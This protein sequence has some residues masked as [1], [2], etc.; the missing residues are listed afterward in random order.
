MYDKSFFLQKHTLGA[1]TLPHSQGAGR[2]PPAGGSAGDSARRSGNTGTWRRTDRGVPSQ[3]AATELHIIILS[4]EYWHS[5]FRLYRSNS[6]ILYR[7][8][9]Y[10]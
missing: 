7:I 2:R 5:Y 10:Q 1:G 6:T 8:L 9:E 4:K 3:A